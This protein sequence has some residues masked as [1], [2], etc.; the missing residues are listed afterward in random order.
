[1]EPRAGFEPATYGLRGRRSD[2]LSYRGSCLFFG[3]G[4]IKMLLFG[5][6]FVGLGVPCCFRFLLVCKVLK[7]GVLLGFSLGVGRW[8]SAVSV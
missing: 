3:F 7:V 1:M 6:L 5:V 4:F 8:L 2:Q